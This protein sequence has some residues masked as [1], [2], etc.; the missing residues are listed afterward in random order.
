MNVAAIITRFGGNRKMARALGLT[1]STVRCWPQ[2]GF[3]PSKYLQRVLAAGQALEPPL[4]PA[5]FFAPKEDS[6][7]TPPKER[8]AAD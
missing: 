7:A 6:D 1:E 3:I 4:T 2:T 5:D 8:D